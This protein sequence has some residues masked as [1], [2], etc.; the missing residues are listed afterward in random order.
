MLENA[1][2]LFLRPKSSSRRGA[3]QLKNYNSILV[4]E[5]TGQWESFQRRIAH[6]TEE[7]GK[8][9]NPAYT[10]RM[11][12]K[13]ETERTEERK[14]EAKIVKREKKH[15]AQNFFFSLLSFLPSNLLT[16]HWIRSRELDVY[17]GQVTH[18]C[19]DLC[20][21]KAFAVCVT[22]SQPLVASIL[23]RLE[24]ARV[25]RNAFTYFVG[26]DHFLPWHGIFHVTTE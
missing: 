3:K 19:I 22:R 14:N 2:D 8:S 24:W 18:D 9:L 20:V 4:V 25:R 12:E 10:R 7:G 1:P 26:T 21:G 17:N 6:L 11:M 13:L 16:P 23:P 5:R 15:S